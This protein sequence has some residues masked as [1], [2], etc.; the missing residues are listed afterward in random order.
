MPQLFGGRLDHPYLAMTLFTGIILYIIGYV[1]GLGGFQ[2]TAA[3][4][5]MYGSIPILMGIIG[6]L[7]IGGLSVA[8]RIQDHR[9]RR[10]T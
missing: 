8:G 4:L 2:W 10:S 9:Y 3:Y 1:L 5:G 7:I 6:Y